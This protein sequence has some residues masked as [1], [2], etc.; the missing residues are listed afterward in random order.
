MT[1]AAEDAANA[2]RHAQLMSDEAYAR[3]LMEQMEREHQEVYGRPLGTAPPRGAHIEHQ[4]QQQG[5][6]YSNLNYIPRQRGG[7][8]IAHN[9][10]HSQSQ[11]QYGNQGSFDG[12]RKDELE[13]LAE[14]FGKFADS[15]LLPPGITPCLILISRW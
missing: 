5:R 12:Q 10:Q 7:Q 8:A 15:K 11:S 9:Q 3:E 6:D 13:Q 2:N 4:R 14:Q 1:T